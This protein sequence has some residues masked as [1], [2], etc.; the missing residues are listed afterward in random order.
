MP[1]ISLREF[2]RRRGVALSAVQKA[3]AD[4]RIGEDAIERA[5]G[6][7]IIGI[8]E[9]RAGEQWDARSDPGAMLKAG[10]TPGNEI[11]STPRG[12][13]TP[14]AAGAD[15]VRAADD[16]TAGAAVT[17]GAGGS[18]GIQ[19]AAADARQPSSAPAAGSD[20][21]AAGGEL[22]QAAAAA[23]AKDN[24]YLNAR[25]EREEIERDTARLKLLGDLKL[26]VSVEDVR[27][28][29]AQRYR[30]VRD[31][32]ETADAQDAIAIAAE[33]GRPDL[34]GKVESILR[35]STKLALNQLADGAQAEIAAA[36]EQLER[37]VA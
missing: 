34:V 24:R 4:G 10:K 11:L 35:R 23:P 28:T 36:R 2:A 8:D 25:A 6:G 7:R 22:D 12:R 14:D 30:V 27:R 26:V 13:S 15:D 29:A 31:L 33:V 1:K 37:A 3:I 17:L 32:L 19:R 16:K 18:D 5:E 9:L 21:A 20:P